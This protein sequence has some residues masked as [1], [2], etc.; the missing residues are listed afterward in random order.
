MLTQLHKVGTLGSF[1][2]M[3]VQRIPRY[4]LLLRDLLKNTWEDHPDYENIQKALKLIESIGM[5][6]N[7]GM[8]SNT[9]SEMLEAQNYFGAHVTVLSPTRC[10][11][12]PQHAFRVA[13]TLCLK[14]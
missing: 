9:S 1:L 3:P 7:L 8:S 2:I 12:V 6:V 5:D 4:A 11:L 14:P 13:K 10:V